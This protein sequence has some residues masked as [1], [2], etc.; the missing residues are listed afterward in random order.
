A[1]REDKKNR[2]VLPYF[3]AAL[4]AVATG[5]GPAGVAGGDGGAGAVTGVTTTPVTLPLTPSF[6]FANRPRCRHL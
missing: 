2:G 5:A 4:D 6:C 3:G 1:R